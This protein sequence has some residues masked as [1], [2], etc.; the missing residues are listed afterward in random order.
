METTDSVWVDSVESMDVLNRSGVTEREREVLRLLGDR[1]TNAEIA[2]RLFISVRTVESHV[3]SL[4]TKLG[5]ANRRDLSVF[6]VAASMRG[7]PVPQ[8][9][10]VG[11]TDEITT[12]E[13]LVS[14]H[15][16]VT[17]TGIGGSGKTRLAIEVGRR[18]AAS[19]DAGA[20]FVDLA[21]IT[22]PD[23][24][25]VALASQ[26]GLDHV[27]ATTDLGSRPRELVERLQDWHGLVILD[28]CEHLLAETAE[29]ASLLV[30][31]CPELRVLVTSREGFGIAGEAIHVVPPL[32]VP[33]STEQAFECE[34]V[35]LFA[36]RVAAARPDLDLERHVSATV[37]ICQRL[38]GLPL[39]IELAAV[40]LVHLT[41][42]EL[43]ER[44]DGMQDLLAA[45]SNLDPRQATLGAAI[46]WSYRLLS[47]A[48]RLLMDR[49][50]VFVGWVDIDSIEKVCM[51]P[52]LH[53]QDA[54]T[55]IQ[56]L[57]WKS[58][59]VVSSWGSTSRYRMLETVRTYGLQKLGESGGSTAA[60]RSHVQWCVWLAEEADPHLEQ[61]ESSLWLDR[62][63]ANL[64]NLRLGLGHAISST[65]AESSARL[66][67]SLWRFWHMRGDIG[68][69]R[70]WGDA[71][72]EICDPSTPERAR[73]LA[74]AGGLAY[75]GGDMETSQRLY[76]EALEITRESGSDREL[77]DSLY[78]AAFAWGF[79]GGTERALRYLDQAEKIFSELGD[80]EGV[81][82]SLWGWGACAQSAGRFEEARPR[83]ERALELLE[84]L[85]NTFLLAW[86]HWMYANVLTKLKDGASAKPH[87]AGALRMFARA[88]DQSGKIMLL[89]N[90]ARLAIDEGDLDRVAILAGALGALQD[91]SG[92]DLL[93]AFSEQIE[94]LDRVF[95]ALG[96][97]AKSL[98][99]TGRE[100]SDSQV[101]EY[102]SQA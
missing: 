20:V 80:I 52:P 69:G 55:L 82:K 31:G 72:L 51:Y 30:R 12:I 21:P 59:L 60:R 32:Q 37:E 41:P 18:V 3:S 58:L 35:A 97:R 64:A 71:V 70:R 56:S 96:D 67:G 99:H 77:A 14:R 81:A 4:L 54:A 5:A 63:D 68:E 94:G 86:A 39:A 74:A 84:G 11:R 24:L 102:A 34:S 19:F 42:E 83:L 73:V 48:E 62:L 10:I 47:D 23:L 27:K 43:A 98:T 95:E 33:E 87:L 25:P 13:G 26:L 44:L 1:L 7:F 17:L 40:Q 100:M 88:G 16:L 85:N 93:A 61:E 57:V 53:D 78:N 38:D 6:R 50:S 28:N 76:E 49:V 36:V 92:M 75:W 8:A 45:R 15:R 65:D 66:Y 22:D 90:Y 29:L 9:E 91:T 79:G 89:Q 2:D 101:I 46:D